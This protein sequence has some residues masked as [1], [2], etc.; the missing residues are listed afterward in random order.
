MLTPCQVLGLQQQTDRDIPLAELITQEE[1]GGTLGNKSARK[2]LTNEY[3]T[4]GEVVKSNC[5][6][7]LQT[8]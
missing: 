4:H 7:L 5:G 2:F 3:V 1:G 8:G 6:V